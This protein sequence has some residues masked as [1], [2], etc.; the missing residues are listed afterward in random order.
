MSGQAQTAAAVRGA[1][2]DDRR[3]RVAEV[4]AA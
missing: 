1:K 2:G 4:E 3:V